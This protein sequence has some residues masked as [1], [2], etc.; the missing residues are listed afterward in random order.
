MA[1]ESNK[2][3]TATDVGMLMERQREEWLLLRRNLETLRNAKKEEIPLGVSAGMVSKRLLN[4]RKGSLSANLTAI[5]NG[6]RPCFLCR[7]ARPEEQEYLTWGDY[8]ILVNPYPADEYHY[9]IVNRD[10]VPQ[11]IVGRVADM[12]E[13]ARMLE[14][15]CIFYNGAKCGASAPDHMHF[16][17]ITV[18]AVGNFISKS[19]E[20]DK[21]IETGASSVSVHKVATSPFGYFIID[22]KGSNDVNDLFNRVVDSL[23]A[24]DSEEPMMNVLAF[25]AGESVRVVVIPRRKHRPDIYGADEGKMLVSPASLEMAGMFLT[26]RDSDFM[27]LDGD[28]ASEIYREV[29]YSDQEFNEFISRL[30]R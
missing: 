13:L 28:M 24:H 25:N 29:V 15:E 26:S 7:K 3:I 1:K 27:R 17:A 2:N 23:P 4:Y 14:D 8:E 12:V 22:I 5:A 19:E 16:Q 6:E 9:T 30:T 20:Y 18:N 21:L 10:H 11:S